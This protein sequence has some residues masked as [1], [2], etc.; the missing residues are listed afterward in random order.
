MRICV[1]PG[2]GIGPEVIG[3]ALPT[4]RALAPDAELVEAEAG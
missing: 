2:D 3:A 4:L 1:I